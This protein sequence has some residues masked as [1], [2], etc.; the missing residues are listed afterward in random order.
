MTPAGILLTGGA[1]RR[2]GTDKATII[3]GGETL[4]RRS[5]RLLGAVCTTV[6][7][8]GP[9]VSGC[10]AV[11]EDPPGEGPLAAVLAGAARLEELAVGPSPIVVLACD[12]PRLTDAALRRVATH[13]GA[14]SVV[15]VV[16]GRPQ[17]ACTRWSIE[18]R[19]RAAVAYAAGERGL[20]VLAEMPDLVA[21]PTDDDADAFSD[22][23]RPEDLPDGAQPPGSPFAA[24]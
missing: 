2:M 24:T 3:V 4:A 19:T 13:P 14:A 7:E 17:W 8:V 20:R 6:V 22:A 12:L 18:A 15:P 9:G 11:R 16:A 1:S 5:A 23:D 10:D 21:L